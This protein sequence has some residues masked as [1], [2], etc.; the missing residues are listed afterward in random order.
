MV[1]AMLAMVVFTVYRQFAQHRDKT[2]AQRREY[3]A[4][5]SELRDDVRR[6][7]ADQRA[8]SNWNLPAPDALLMIAQQRERLWER[9]ENDAVTFMARFGTSPQPLI[10]ALKEPELSPLST[11][12][13]VC[14]SAVTRFVSTFETVEGLPTGVSIADYARIELCG[15]V[16]AG[17]ALARTC[18]TS[19]ATLVGPDLL[20]I[21]VLTAPEAVEEWDWVKW[22]P[23][24]RSHKQDAVGSMRMIGGALGEILDLLPEGITSRVPFKA[25]TSES[26]LP[27]LLLIVDGVAL[28]EPEREQLAREGVCVMELLQEWGELDSYTAFRF[29]L[30]PRTDG[31][32]ELTT[33]RLTA[34]PFTL[35]ADLTPTALALATAR[36]MAPFGSAEEAAVET[37]GQR[38]VSDPTRSAE[39]VDL[40]GIGDV[41]DYDPSRQITYRDGPSRLNVPFAVTPEGVPVHLDIKEN[42]QGGMGPHG[43]LIGATGSGKSEVLR[44]M[45]LAMALTHSPEQLNFVLVDFKGGATF[46]GMSDLP[47][48]SAT[49]TNLES[50]LSL[51]DRMEEALHGEMV[52]R[53]ELLRAAGNYANVRE[54][55]RARREGKHQEQPMPALFIILD[56]FSELLTAKPEFIETFVAIGR[57]GRSLEVHLLLATQRL[58]ES[59][60]RG[61]ES[62]LSYRIGL[63]T[64]STQDSRAVLGT[65]DAFTLPAV[66]G[67]GY[68]KTAGEGMRQFRASYVAAPPKARRADPVTGPIRQ[69]AARVL[70]FTAA[71]VLSR[72]PVEE[73]EPAPQEAAPVVKA[74]DAQWQDMTTVDIAVTKL[75]PLEPRAHQVWLPPLETP[76]PLD[77]LFGDLV[78]TPELGLHS[79]S[80]RA[81]GRLTVP[82]GIADVPR[83][84]RR[85]TLTMDLSGGAGNLAIIG[86]PQSGKSTAMRTLIMA[87]SLVNTPRE[88]QFYVLDF[89]GGTFA[90]FAR[91][92]H[93]SAVATRD[94]PDIVARVIA[95]ITGL[96]ADREA[97]FRKNDIDSIASYRRGREEGRYDDGFGD[98]YLVVDGW[99]NMKS[100][101][102]DLDRTIETIAGRGLA[103]GVHLLVTS[104]RKMDLRQ[105][106][107]TAMG[108][109]LELRL[110]EPRESSIGHKLAKLVPEGRPGRGL[111]ESQH[112]VL[113]GL[114]RID[115]DAD[116]ETLSDGVIEAWRAIGEAWRGQPG[117]KLRLL[118]ELVELEQIQEH[119]QQHAPELEQVMIGINEARL[120]PIG[121]DLKENPHLYLMGDSRTGKSTALRAYTR[122]VRR[123]RKPH[124]AQFFL[125]DF[126]RSLL[127]EIHDHYLAGY[128]TT[129]EVTTA[130]MKE[131][132]GLLRQRLPGKDVTPQQLRERSWWSGP[133]FFI[134]IDDYDLV[135]T[136]RGNPLDPIVE[137]LSQAGDLGLHVI[138]A[139]RSGGAARAL[140][141]PLLRGM[142]DLGSPALLLPGDP[143]EGPI[144]A[145]TKFQPGPAGRAQLITRQRGRELVQLAHAAPITH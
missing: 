7:T 31:A 41:R 49:I 72:E 85:E 51:V 87:L 54:Y 42:A 93:I 142:I 136:T 101:F 108:A 32:V 121:L 73:E 28:S 139:R 96:M 115:G 40:L 29:L 16:E 98:V 110:G 114:P 116:P 109:D 77:R 66:P 24:A 19:L 103:L 112:Q 6:G 14:L 120:A 23:H 12:D 22:L 9:T 134:V 39:L 18:M 106:L 57:L 33:A 56:E 129:H 143:E 131:I 140:Y 59:K 95:E 62:H 67:V 61:L 124:E 91:G 84:Q 82:I 126:R 118:P 92:A 94:R 144:V 37:T 4:Y 80:W 46:A 105:S 78:V 102:M 11:A 88:A 83:E 133:E 27:Q 58:E 35:T 53:Q 8:F 74:G 79:P 26:A 125:V 100:D 135:N 47:H 97:Y 117:P 34:R 123:M 13:P 52:R 71:P 63:R 10:L 25:R 45:V 113:L 130:A 64:F 5:L 99:N 127:E 30:E 2:N 111:S 76:E 65:G 86:G 36:R 44:T 69:A 1:V 132:A 104:N 141:E 137:L 3:L 15:G 81:R 50:E 48:V 55:E 128:Y 89:G 70:P 107:Q 60:L 38:G 145:K 75:R 90:G 43:L 17:R 119:V 21:A 122:E 138:V 20:K 68:L